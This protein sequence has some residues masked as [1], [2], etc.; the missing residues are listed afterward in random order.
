VQAYDQIWVKHIR[1]ALMENRFRLVQ[2][3]IAS[4]N[5][6]EEKVFDV[7]IRMLDTQGREVLPS[8]FLPA[9][10]RNDLMKNIDRWVLERFP[11][12]PGQA[13][14]PTCCSCASR[15]TACSMAR[16]WT[17]STTC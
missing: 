3:P 11:L 8:E 17:G 16:W 1:A 5:G 9:A 6:S 4:L 2:Q 10:A 14:P 12:L 15:A 13:R 7:A